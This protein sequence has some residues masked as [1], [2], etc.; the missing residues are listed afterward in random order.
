MSEDVL[1][2]GAGIG[3]LSTALSLSPTGR[4]ITILERDQAPPS[5]DPDVTFLDWH[6][7][8]AGHVRQSHAFLARLRTIIKTSHPRLLEELKALGVRDLTFDMMLTEDQLAQYQPEPED[9]DLT[10]ITSRRT[11][12]EP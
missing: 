6:R 3:G 9:E 4:Q 12:L 8:G 1:V 7:Q 10:I 11:T 2:I 5:D